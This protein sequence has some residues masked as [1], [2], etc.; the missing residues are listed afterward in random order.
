MNKSFRVMVLALMLFST[1]KVVSAL[2]FSASYDQEVTVN[3]NP[4]AAFKVQLQDKSMKASTNLGGVETFMIRNDSGTYNFVPSQKQA[5]KLPDDARPNITDE[6]PHYID[7][8][9]KNG[10]KVTGSESKGGY[11]CDIY[12]FIDPNTKAASK[13][14]VWKEKQFPVRIEVNAPEGLTAVEFK[15]IDLEKSIEGKEFQ[16]PEGITV[17]SYE[18]MARKAQEELQKAAQAGNQT[19]PVP[20]DTTT[21]VTAPVVE[22]GAEAPANTQ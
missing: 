5:T 16:I 1:F 4:I 10:A 9:N 7:F 2:A 14:W 11:E 13:A 18:E 12:E 17:T 15:N 20:A 6:L 21:P 8:L 3:G 22:A 19:Q